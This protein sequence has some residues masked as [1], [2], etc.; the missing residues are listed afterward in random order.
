MAPFARLA[1]LVAEDVEPFLLHRII[2]EFRRLE[3]T[4]AGGHDVLHQRRVPEHEVRRVRVGLLAVAAFEESGFAVLPL[5]LVLDVVHLDRAARSKRLGILRGGHRAVGERVV[6]TGPSLVDFL[7]A[8]AAVGGRERGM[9]GHG[10]G[11]AGRGDRF[12]LAA[13]EGGEKQERRGGGEGG[14]GGE[15]GTR[16]HGKNAQT[17]SKR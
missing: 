15:R 1:A 6:R 14:A 5:E 3:A 12:A 2:G 13:A 11:G 17:E 4:A 7:V 10:G 9:R 16:R 8:L